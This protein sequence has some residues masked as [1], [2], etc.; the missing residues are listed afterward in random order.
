M[1]RMFWFDGVSISSGRV[2]A[3]VCGLEARV[4]VAEAISAPAISTPSAGGEGVFV[5]FVVGGGFQ[6]YGACK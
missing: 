2:K 4:G 6:C 3:A 1:L 5:V